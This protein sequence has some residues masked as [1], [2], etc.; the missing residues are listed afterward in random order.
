MS[1]SG[2]GFP[3]VRTPKDSPPTRLS[4]VSAARL[5]RLAADL[6]EQ[7]ASVLAFIAA[8]RLATGTQLVRRFWLKEGGNPDRQ[9]RNGRRALKRLSDWRVLDPLPGRGR[10]GTRGGS[11]TIIYSVGAAG[12]RLLARRGLDRRRLG[13]PGDRHISHTL[14]ITELLVR[15]H[16]AEATGVLECIEA[17]TE[18][19][20]WRAFLGA[21][22]ARLTLKPDLL[23]RV[24]APGSDF[25]TRWAVE[26]DMATESPSTIRAKAQRYLEH[27]RSGREQQ[28]HGVYPKVLWVVPD[29]RRAEQIMGVLA[30]LPA[31]AER[32]FSVCQ[33]HD[34]TA[35]LITEARS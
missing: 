10:G 15:L 11:D 22:G 28:E 9:A 5:E 32:L 34:T 6:G 29:A 21:M 23:L 3:L 13:T 27:Y 25:E 31:P 30:R 1:R 20:C 33:F 16:E 12:A 19:E 35:L 18:P 26:M 4:R 2:P 8:A 17:Q 14:T 24:A 7:D